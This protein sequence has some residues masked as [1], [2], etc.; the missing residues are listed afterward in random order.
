MSPRPICLA[1][2][3]ADHGGFTLARVH[4]ASTYQS[5]A[6]DQPVTFEREP[7]IDGPG[8]SGSTSRLP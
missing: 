3:I 6:A 1:D 4:G 5:N 8:H 2:P 7:V